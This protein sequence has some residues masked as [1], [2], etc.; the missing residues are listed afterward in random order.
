M[1]RQKDSIA[2]IASIGSWH[3]R[4][5]FRLTKIS[6]MMVLM[7]YVV[8]SRSRTS[9]DADIMRAAVDDLQK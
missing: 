4:V 8:V 7:I 2:L 6:C 5:V 9:G 1:L 3:D